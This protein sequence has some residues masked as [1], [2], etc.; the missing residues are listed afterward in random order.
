[1]PTE[2]RGAPLLAQRSF[3]SLW[4]GQLIS[5]LGDRLTYLALVGLLAQHTHEFRDPGASLLLSV[6]ANL[7]LAPVLLL[8]PFAGAWV[9]RWNLRRTL[10]ISDL[11]RSGIVFLIPVSYTVTHNIGPAMGLVFLLFT[12]NVFFLPAKSAIT[13]EIVSPSQ[14]LAANALL[15]VAGIIA[16]SVGALCGGWVV[17]HLG[18]ATA[19]RIDG[20][21][22]LVSVITLAL[23]AY[24]PGAHRASLAAI[25]WRGYLREIG[26][27]F[28]T[29][30][31]SSRV[32][33]GLTSLAAVWIGGGFL[34]VAGNL[35]IQR[36]A[37]IPGMERL[38][39]LLATLGLGSGFGT[40]WVNGRGRRVPRPWL[41]GGGL[42]VVT[43][44]LTAFAVSSRFAVFAASAFL[45]GLA[46]APA[47]V[48]SETLIQEGTELHQRGRVFSARDF[49]MRL[50]F[51]FAVSIA[52]WITRAFG[53]EPALILCAGLIAVAGV[54]AI[55]WGRRDP[56]LMRPGAGRPA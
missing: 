1:M 53:T 41:L 4:W 13:P 15:S 24:K 37:S 47:F 28:S 48:L 56:G 6:L 30:R 14:L 2:S 55:A 32:G 42:L 17:D 40:W 36:A 3:G 54:L 5:I 26:E 18:W 34:H 20:V 10:I 31:H 46:A 38:G 9:D 44:G 11:V 23:V 16:T 19:M 7:M 50:L 33:L 43:L 45:I 51:L 22:Y 29:L 52:G 39:I 49:F 25:S 35:H 21:T 12:C 27:G 8:S